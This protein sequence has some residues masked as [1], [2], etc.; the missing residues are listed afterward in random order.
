MELQGQYILHDN[1]VVRTASLAQEHY[2]IS[3]LP[4]DALLEAA[5]RNDAFRH[6]VS[7][8]SKSLAHTVEAA[9]ADTIDDKR[10]RGAARSIRQY[11]I[12]MTSRAT[13]S[14]SW[15]TSGQ[16]GFG[17]VTNLTL[18]S[19]RWRETL[20]AQ[21]F[22]RQATQASPHGL[23]GDQQV[24][25]NPA[26][27]LGSATA[28]ILV[29]PSI[30]RSENQRS[31]KVV[32][33]TPSLRRVMEICAAPA[34][35]D[36]V[37]SSLQ[38]QTSAEATVLQKFLTD[39][40][41]Q[42]MLLTD[43]NPPKNAGNSFD[44]V[45]NH[46]PGLQAATAAQVHSARAVVTFLNEH[47]EGPLETPR[48][49]L[50]EVH[51]EG[52][53]P[54]GGTLD[55]TYQARVSSIIPDLIRL[56]RP[57]DPV[58]TAFVDELSRQTGGAEVPLLSLPRSLVNTAFTELGA[59]RSPDELGWDRLAADLFE[60]GVRSADFSAEITP[61]DIAGLPPL[62]AGACAPSYDV[63]VRGSIGRAGGLR[64]R[65]TG[66]TLHAGRAA[67][68]FADLRDHAAE[69]IRRGAQPAVDGGIRVAELNC[70][71][72]DF[73]HNNVAF[74]ATALPY[75]VTVNTFPQL[76]SSQQVPL[77]DILIGVADET[78]PYLRLASTGE[79]LVVRTTSLLSNWAYPGY[80]RLLI[81]VS[82]HGLTTP[83]WSWGHLGM[84][85]RRPELTLG[86]VVVSPAQ[87]T[88]PPRAMSDRD[89][90]DWRV[91]YDV[92]RFVSHGA[93]DRRL[94]L[95]LDAEEHRKLLIAAHGRGS[96]F[97]EEAADL[98][99]AG[100]ATDATGGT[101]A[102]EFVLSAVSRSTTA[103][104]QLPHPLRTDSLAAAQPPGVQWWYYKIELA[105]GQQNALLGRIAHV[106]GDGG[107]W[108]F[109]RYQERSSSAQVRVRFSAATFDGHALSR[110]LQSQ[111]ADGMLQ[112]FSLETYYR[113][114]R[115][116]GGAAALDRREEVFCRES[117]VVASALAGWPLPSGGDTNST[118][119]LDPAISCVLAYLP[120]FQLD[121][122]ATVAL[123]RR[124]RK[125][126][127]AEMADLDGFS[128]RQTHR[129][130]DRLLAD[131]STEKP[132][133]APGSNLIEAIQALHDA[134]PRLNEV[135]D[136]DED[137]LD[138]VRDSAL[139][140]FC[141]RLGLSR[142]QEYVTVFAAERLSASTIYRTERRDTLG[143]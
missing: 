122:A 96:G 50:H 65:C 111:V 2:C 14:G 64:L 138:G 140:M 9:L 12:R 43:L 141:N 19:P 123:L 39:L 74:S 58:L 16:A 120:T 59:S 77:S 100:V 93:G 61:D 79:Q 69:L 75:E 97:V 62:P 142:A 84:A 104:P 92:P 11:F 51:T 137:L 87:Y 85:S 41:D 106:F 103:G 18:G 20:H 129:T 86:G 32:R 27:H 48:S 15:A 133:G 121:P 134:S 49:P 72:K 67:G 46:L 24:F 124:V 115:R 42:G 56:T 3:T 23:R 25:A 119:E 31:R 127:A 40:V 110:W 5:W 30:S 126:Y 99:D 131:R 95:D 114:V 17:S 4:D 98:A 29:A 38:R 66:V 112:S 128:P 60:R 107:R 28:E 109:V 53:V 113:E 6:A 132:P 89:V 90:T 125:R 7:V 45:R 80:A 36:Q 88:L 10:R 44:W 117:A 83:A 21:L 139:H 94:L 76:P 37:I 68:R 78:R 101:Y 34:R 8:R 116:Y 108:F 47:Q 26:V 73:G 118:S 82:D 22:S 81:E 135:A 136:V 33:L 57:V 102:T 71:S 143:R 105:I 54:I 52:S 130:V 1:F 13:P 70:L 35:V 55:D 63:F 91:G